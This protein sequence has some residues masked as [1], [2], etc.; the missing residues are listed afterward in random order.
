MVC[1]VV[2]NNYFKQKMLFWA[3]VTIGWVWTRGTGGLLGEDSR[4][5]LETKE[6]LGLAVIETWERDIPDFVDRE[7]IATGVGEG[8]VKQQSSIVAT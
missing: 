3:W 6:E 1:L 5:G 7:E 4:W 2:K 8:S